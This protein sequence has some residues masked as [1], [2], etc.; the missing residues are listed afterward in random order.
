MKVVILCG[1]RGTRL[2][3]KTEYKPKPMVEIGTKPMLW[4][5]MKIYSHYG[6]NEFVLCLGY[7]S[8][9]IK[10]YFYNYELLNNDITIGLGK[11]KQIEV[12]NSKSEIDWRITLAE[13][14]EKTMTGS[15][16][17][18]IE[19]YID[20]DQFMLTYGDGLSNVDLPQLIE[21]HNSHGKIG[22]VTSVRPPSRFGEI[23]IDEDC[24]KEFSE[25]P[26]IKE[27]YINGGFFVFEKDFFDY[28]G[29]S[30]D[31]SL[32]LEQEPLEKLACDDQLRAYKHNG[33]WH[34]M[35]TYRDLKLL[36]SMWEGK[37]L[38]KDLRFNCQGGNN[39]PWKVWED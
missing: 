29:N 35:D 16:I 11:N 31:D 24:V 22:T 14:G 6:F 7:K 36:N 10:N 13:T 2:R 30:Y 20:S 38:Q 15:R 34:C 1:G 5:I 26:Q 19:R 8:D 28:L 4:H 32:I 9:M 3:E 18:R 37:E 21:F 17:K 33:F 12:H 25:K 27:G 39:P 23:V